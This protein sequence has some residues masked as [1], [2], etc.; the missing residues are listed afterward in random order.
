VEEG[1]TSN[2]ELPIATGLTR[3]HAR[4]HN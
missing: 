3:K 2:S 4:V 1:D